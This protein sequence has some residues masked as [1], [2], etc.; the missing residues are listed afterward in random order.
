VGASDFLNKPIVP[1]ELQTRVRTRL[2]QQQIWKLT[3]VDELTGV[4][5]RSK[6]MFENYFG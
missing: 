1:K 3:E 2:E 4:G 5:L 6:R